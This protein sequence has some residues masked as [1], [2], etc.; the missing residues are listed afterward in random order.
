[1]IRK[2]EDHAFVVSSREDMRLV[3]VIAAIDIVRKI[4]QYTT[5]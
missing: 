3:G 2:A 4:L 5:A 1:M